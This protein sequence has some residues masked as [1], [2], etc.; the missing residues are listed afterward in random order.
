MVPSCTLICS[1][2]PPSSPRHA[3]PKGHFVARAFQP[4]S[5]IGMRERERACTPWPP[6]H[7]LHCGEVRPIHLALASGLSL[8]VPAVRHCQNRLRCS[9]GTRAPFSHRA[10]Q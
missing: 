8:R 4:H 1:F 10:H 5:H 3:W 7:R 6:Q 2:P 9:L